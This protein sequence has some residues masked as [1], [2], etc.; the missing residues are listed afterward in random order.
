M[1]GR[2]PELDASVRRAAIA[3]AKRG[4]CVFPTR[5]GGKEPRRGLSWPRVATADL[6]ALERAR[7]RPGEN[8][9]IAAKPSGLVFIDLDQPKPGCEL[10]A[11]WCEWLDEPGIRDGRDVLAILADR[12]R[13]GWPHTFTVTTPSG[14]THLYYLALPGRGIGN[15]PLGPMIDIRGGGDG[16]GGYVL[17]P[18]SVLGGRAY[19]ITDDR[20]AVPL[21]GWIADLLDPP[22]RADVP[23]G[24]AETGADGR[25]AARLDGL[26]ATVLDAMQGE[27]NNVLHWAACRAAEMVTA[28]QLTEDQV[29]DSLGRAAACVGLD[30]GEAARTIASALR[31]A[32][33]SYARDSAR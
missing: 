22:R 14:G 1:M 17:G 11:R 21:P 18:G 32:L 30:D 23:P 5:P 3:S 25:V 4:W 8:Y 20:H 15:K 7:W 29:H 13:E 10:P 28:G 33:R 9:G 31:H 27:R 19:E 16:D 2:D 24:R 26:I 12:A 6:A